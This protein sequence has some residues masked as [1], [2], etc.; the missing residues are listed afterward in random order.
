MRSPGRRPSPAAAATPVASRPS[1]GQPEE[2]PMTVRG[3]RITPFRSLPERTVRSCRTGEP[4][5]CRP[6]QGRENPGCVTRPCAGGSARATP[7]RRLVRRP[8]RSAPHRAG[9]VR[10]PA[11]TGPRPPGWR[12]SPTSSTAARPLAGSEA[13][14]TFTPACPAHRRRRTCP[15][16]K[17]DVP[18]GPSAFLH[19]ADDARVPDAPD[20]VIRPPPTPDGPAT[21]DCS[22]CRV[23]VHRR[24]VEASA[25][26]A[27]H[28][29]RS[30]SSSG[31]GR[32]VGVAAASPP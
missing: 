8:R 19:T 32:I 18:R 27:C 31:E 22:G 17:R 5:A 4:K 23:D 15:R 2:S 13:G 16:T 11:T 6:P 10:A 7:L 21:R 12:R 25:A 14:H 24:H 26:C 9:P 20:P 28:G 1:S 30:L 29:R 3:L